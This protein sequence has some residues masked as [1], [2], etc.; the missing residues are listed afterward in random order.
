MLALTRLRSPR[1]VE[2][3]TFIILYELGQVETSSQNAL[4]K[5]IPIKV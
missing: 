1:I 5:H 2:V 3:F 4:F